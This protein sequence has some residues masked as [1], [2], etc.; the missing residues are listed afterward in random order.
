MLNSCVYNLNNIDFKY[1]N[2]NDFFIDTNVLFWYHYAFAKY[3]YNNIKIAEYQKKYPEF[4][5]QFIEKNKNLFTSSINLSE[6]FYRIE[7]TE[8]KLYK[9]NNNNPSLKLKDYRNIEVE[10]NKLKKTLN[11]IYKE[12]KNLYTIKDINFTNNNLLEYINEMSTHKCDVYDHA[13]LSF[14]KSKKLLNV[15]SDDSDFTSI[16]GI[17]VYTLNNKAI[18]NNNS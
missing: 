1:L 4:I 8:Y 3:N 5:E 12:I 17:N 15:I 11:A 10:R 7:M 13:I 14:I 18:K 6:L 2:E 16:S 9:K